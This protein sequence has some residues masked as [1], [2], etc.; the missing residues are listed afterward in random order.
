MGKY[1]EDGVK[2]VNTKMGNYLME[3]VFRK[4]KMNLKTINIITQ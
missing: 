2:E 1:G 4:P 3:R